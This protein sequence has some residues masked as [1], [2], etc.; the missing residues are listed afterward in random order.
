MAQARILLVEDERFL[1]SMYTMLLEGAGYEVFSAVNGEEAEEKLEL[2]SFDLILSDNNM[3]FKDGVDVLRAL[4][5]A[6]NAIP[7]ILM[8]GR[9]WLDDGTGLEDLCASHGAQFIQKPAQNKVLLAAIEEM[10]A[11]K[12]A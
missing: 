11:A 9:P 12:S 10:L 8:S 1:R 7:F 5:A 6:G 4:R 3:P 2:G